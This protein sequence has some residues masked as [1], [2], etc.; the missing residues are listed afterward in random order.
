MRKLALISFMT[1]LGAALSGCTKQAIQLTYDKQE[2][3]ID[4][5]VEAVLKQDEAAT[6]DYPDGVVRIRLSASTSDEGDPQLEKGGTISFYYGGYTLP[7]TSISTSNLFAT[8]LKDLAE[9]SGWGNVDESVFEVEEVVIGK[10][11]LVPGL[12]KGLVGVRKGDNVLIL[13]SGKYGWGNHSKGIVPARSA[14]AWQIW[15]EDVSNE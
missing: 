3:N 4:K 8:N 5:V 10:G 6:V 14:L 2:A 12:E 11:E 9:A 1:I 7:S 13:F 15:V